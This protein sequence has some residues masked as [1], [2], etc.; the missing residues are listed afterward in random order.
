MLVSNF[1]LGYNPTFGDPS[2]P[3]WGRAYA[4]Q[5]T[6]LSA[7]KIEFELEFRVTYMYL[8]GTTDAD[9]VLKSLHDFTGDDWLHD[10]HGYYCTQ[11]SLLAPN[12]SDIINMGPA[13]FFQREWTPYLQGYGILRVPVVP[14]PQSRAHLVPQSKNPIPVLLN[15]WH[16]DDRVQTVD[17]HDQWSVSQCDVPLSTGKA[18]NEIIPELYPIYHPF[19]E[20]T[21]VHLHGPVRAVTSARKARTRH[22]DQEP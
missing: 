2:E 4:L 14:D 7:E 5:V 17:N 19:F 10:A 1:N 13:I 8:G 20:D 21:V 12:T 9:P 16:E 6:N 15:A 18:Y 22:P 11:S 3:Q